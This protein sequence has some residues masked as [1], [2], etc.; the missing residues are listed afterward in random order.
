MGQFFEKSADF[1]KNSLFFEKNLSLQTMSKVN[2]RSHR[3]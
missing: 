2:Q 1:F 3:S